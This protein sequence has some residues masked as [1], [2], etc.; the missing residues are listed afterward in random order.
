MIA[1]T[2]TGPGTSTAGLGVD[3]AP[4]A[5]LAQLPALYSTENV[6]LADKQLIAKWFDP[7]GSMRLYAAE[8]DPATGEC[9]GYVSTAHGSEWTYFSLPD[10]ADERI[11]LFGCVV[12]RIER[13]VHFT[14]T[15]LATLRRDRAAA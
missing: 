1:I 13:D 6:E 14:P 2:Q 12:P 10:L 7:Y 4:Q 5:V 11:D 15:N 8:I 9:F 3:F